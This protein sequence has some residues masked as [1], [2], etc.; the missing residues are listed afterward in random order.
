MHDFSHLKPDRIRQ[1]L[2][3][4]SRATEDIPVH[5]IPSEFSQAAVLIPFIWEQGEWHLLFIR[6]A[7]HDD[8]YHA[9]QVAFAGGKYESSDKNLEDT[10]LREAHEEIGLHPQDVTILGQLNLH[11]SI[12]Q[13]QITP[14]V[15]HIPWPYE[16]TLEQSEVARA[17]SIP[18]NWLAN[19]AHH[20]MQQRQLRENESFPVAYFDEFDGEVLWGATARMTLSLITLLK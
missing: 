1:K 6:R 9:G 2:T 5:L 19:P 18:L 10:A 15:G 16:L 20:R 11:H 13:F 14:I 17:F 7:S 12:S 8:D 4:P 3:R